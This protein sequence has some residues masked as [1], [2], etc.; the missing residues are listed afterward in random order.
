[1]SM[2]FKSSIWGPHYWFVLHTT[3]ITY[4]MKPNEITRKKYYDFIQNIPLIIPNKDVAVSFSKLLDQYPVS[5]YLDSRDS[6]LKW[7][8]FIHNKINTKLGKK[9]ISVEQMI[10]EYHECYKPDEI[11]QFDNRKK[12]KTFLII[13]SIL[14]LLYSSS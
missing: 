8:N 2:E 9:E 12:R 10:R 14:F 7:I 5:P 4:P 13:M 11:I 1:M 6:F 3:A